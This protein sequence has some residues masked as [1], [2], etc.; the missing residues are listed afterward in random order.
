MSTIQQLAYI[1]KI[2]AAARIG[3]YPLPQ[4]MSMAVLCLSGPQY[5]GC[6][7]VGHWC[8]PNLHMIVHIHVW[9]VQP[10]V[11]VRL[12][13]EMVQQLQFS[14]GEVCVHAVARLLSISCDVAVAAT[15]FSHIMI[16]CRIE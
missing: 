13:C 8:E 12:H 11:P 6:Y 15:R 7:E 1:N 10:R 16:S 3:M 2:S 4:S 14:N 5:A 9:I